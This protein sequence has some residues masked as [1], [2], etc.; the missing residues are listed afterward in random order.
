MHVKSFGEW[1]CKS[2]NENKKR[3][4]STRS[5]INNEDGWMTK[6]YLSHDVCGGQARMMDSLHRYKRKVVGGQSHRGLGGTSCFTAN[7]RRW[8]LFYND[9]TRKVSVSAILRGWTRCSYG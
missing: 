7:K 2:K 8:A 3:A 4:V 1:S 6:M 9:A 5:N